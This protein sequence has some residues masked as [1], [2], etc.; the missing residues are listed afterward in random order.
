VSEPAATSGGSEELLSERRGPVQWIIF[1][2]PQARNALT[3][4]MYSKLV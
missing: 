1:N 3:W 2:R 4:N